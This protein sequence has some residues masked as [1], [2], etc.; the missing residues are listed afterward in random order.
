MPFLLPQM[1]SYPGT[2][3][4][5]SFQSTH[6]GL[7]KDDSGGSGNN[8]QTLGPESGRDRV[9]EGSQPLRE[10]RRVGLVVRSAEVT[11]TCKAVQ[12]GSSQ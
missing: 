1:P 10:P 4:E 11:G 2:P 3:V 6:L 7:V 5:S 9:K 8:V 12:V